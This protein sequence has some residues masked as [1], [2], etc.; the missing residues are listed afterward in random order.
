[1]KISDTLCIVFAGLIEAAIVRH[2]RR[3]KGKLAGVV[4]HL[5]IP[6]LLLLNIFTRD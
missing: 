3:L 2:V 5:P 4:P 1:M 6:V